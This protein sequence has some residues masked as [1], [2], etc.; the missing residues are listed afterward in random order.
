M[1]CSLSHAPHSSP[2]RADWRV[3][4]ILTVFARYDCD[5][6]A[7]VLSVGERQRGKKK[8]WLSLHESSTLLTKI[9]V[10]KIV[11]PVLDHLLYL[12]CACALDFQK[13]VRSL[14]TK[15]TWAM[16][17]ENIG[18]GKCPFADVCRWRTKYSYLDIDTFGR[19]VP[20]FKCVVKRATL[21]CVM[22]AA[23]VAH[24][25]W[26]TFIHSCELKCPYCESFQ[27]HTS[28]FSSITT[29]WSTA[30]GC[31]SCLKLCWQNI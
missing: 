3:T 11:W 12:I 17:R 25:L 24:K 2:S 26:F 10:K 21:K 14:G 16:V 22:L 13:V 6:L 15:P 8:C 28:D 20:I 30:L 1:H 19:S 29:N 31:A 23:Q 7:A 9:Y 4:Q 5:N 27:P 18:V